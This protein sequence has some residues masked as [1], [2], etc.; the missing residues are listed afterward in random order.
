MLA[1]GGFFGGTGGGLTIAGG[2]ETLT[3]TNTYTGATTIDL[4]ATLQLGNGGSTGSVA[5]DV[6]DNGLVQ[7]DYSGPV[8]VANS[9]SGTG[10]V[11]VVAGTVVVTGTSFIGGNGDDR[12]RRDDAMGRWRAGVPGRRR[13]R[14]GRQRR[15]GHELRRRRHRRRDP[16]LR[17][18]QCEIQSGSLN[19]SGVSTYT[20]STTIDSAGVLALS[21]AGSISNSSNVIVNGIFD[22]SGTTAGTS[23]TSITGSG[24]VGLGARR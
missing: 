16:D 7:F 12:S 2:T 8:T 10:T 19:D 4:G 18:G 20:G 6:V 3:G 17:L 15:A 24:G 9:F 11:E 13:Q 14:G 21:G 23:I 22:I 1:D 5:G